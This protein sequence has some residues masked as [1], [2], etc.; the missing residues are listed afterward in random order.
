LVSVNCPRL[1]ATVEMPVP[2]TDTVTPCASSRLNEPDSIVSAAERALPL[3]VPD[4]DAPA[5]EDGAMGDDS[6]PSPPQSATTKVVSYA[7][8]KSK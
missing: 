8:E 7:S 1:S 3:I 2:A 4:M 5:D 6:V